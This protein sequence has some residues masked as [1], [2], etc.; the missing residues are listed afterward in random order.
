MFNEVIN[1]S[2]KKKKKKKS[3]Y[4]ELINAHA[5]IYSNFAA[6][7]GLK[8]LLLHGLWSIVR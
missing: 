8:F 1:S 3:T 6:K 7:I 5:G 4:K 2:P